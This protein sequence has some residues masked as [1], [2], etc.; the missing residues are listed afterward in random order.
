MLHRLL[1]LV[2]AMALTALAGASAPALAQYQEDYYQDRYDDRYVDDRYVDDRYDDRY[3]DYRRDEYDPPGRV[4]RL[5]H[6]T[7]ELS[8]SPGGGSDW[9]RAVRNRP[10]VQGDRLYADGGALG[11]VQLGGAVLRMAGRTSVDVLTLDEEYAQFEL[12]EGTVNLTVDQAWA[13]QA[14]EIATPMA[15]IVMT[16]RGSIRVDVD[17][18]SG[19][20]DVVVWDGD[21]EAYGTRVTFPLY[22]RDAVRFYDPELYD[23][24][25]FRAPRRDRFDNWALAR[26]DMMR[27][28]VSRQY[29]PDGMIGYSDL[30]QYGSWDR[31]ADYGHVWFPRGVR[32]D[33]APYRNGHWIWQDP[34]G[35]TWVDDSPWGFAPFHYGRWAH[36]G[37]R[38]GWVPGPRRSRAVYAPALVAFVGGSNWS[39]GVSLGSRPVGWF[40]LGP[41]EVYV[42]P[43]HA[44]RDYFRRINISNTVINN[45]VITNVYNNYYVRDTP[46]IQDLQYRYRGL[47]IA[48]T[49]V[50]GDA[51]VR[52][53]SV[54]EARIQL[55][56]RATARAEVR[57]F[58]AVAPQQTS[59]VGAVTTTSRARPSA[60]ARQ[61]TVVARRAPAA[62]VVPFA[63]R[64]QAI[65]RNE[66][67]PLAREQLQSLRGRKADDA[68]ERRVRVVGEPEQQVRR[69]ARQ[70][71]ESE[72]ELP[73]G[74]VT[75]RA[76]RAP[77]AERGAPAS[78][79]QDLEARPQRGER[80]RGAAPAREASDATE[81]PRRG[82][83][84]EREERV[85]V[86]PQR[87]AEPRRAQDAVDPATERG[88][89]RAL[90]QQREAEQRATQERA[91][92]QARGRAQQQREAEQ[93]AERERAQEQA[94]GRAMQQ[95][96]EAEQRAA[97]ERA[98]EQARGRA[99]QQQR[100]AEQR[101]AQERAQESERRAPPVRGRGQQRQEQEEETEEE[102]EE[103]RRGRGRGRDD[104]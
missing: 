64:A 76:S 79:R 46:V 14:Y 91:E 35:W 56:E 27:R 92:E 58:A 36:V 17:P 3:A 7:G 78:Q 19:I 65:A 99:L 24:E 28:S 81:T 71:T 67:R 89:G 23:Y 72:R 75:P 84:A 54:Q 2:P 16:G 34:W 74:Q 98:Q 60:E 53:R 12:T 9:Y 4:G 94:R 13:G 59:L 69:E 96:R 44:S 85:P 63:A 62:D 97:Q 86:A 55:D 42:P 1:M 22:E 88:R 50:P 10:I 93:R 87:G 49:A 21:A 18:R 33:W 66:G 48:T 30:D 43:Y 73:R 77:G 68:Q 20:T 8:F 5:S 83:A 57:R 102:E 82:R 39:V 37:N 95:Q 26:D 80:G 101:A 100:E 31:V 45:T 61:R 103:R 41:R 70:R 29:L 11:E 90:Q 52:G 51:F 38:W 25:T 47:P 6:V 15:A 40:P 32:R 104:R